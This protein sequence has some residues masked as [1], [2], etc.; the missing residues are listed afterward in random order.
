MRAAAGRSRREPAGGGVLAQA[1]RG[2]GVAE[3]APVSGRSG[4]RALAG[5]LRGLAIVA[6]G[7]GGAS[8]GHPRLVGEG[9][10]GPAAARRR[11]AG[12][13]QGPGCGR[14]LRR[15]APELRGPPGGG[16][17]C[18]WRGARAQNRR[19]RG[20]PGAR[21]VPERLGRPL[22][23]PGGRGRRA[24]GRGVMVPSSGPRPRRL[25][26]PRRRGNDGR[27]RRD[28]LRSQRR[29]RSGSQSWHAELLR[30][31]DSRGLA[32]PVAAL[33]GRL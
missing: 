33:A 24:D 22:G 2:R 9:R 10:R 25:R 13:G 31:G 30:R 16:E 29:R 18:P 1:P 28:R 6:R 20:D 17:E 8:A 19:A 3:G 5:A 26:R 27:P 14:H 11:A 23:V 32:S 15:G 7:H 4:R 21:L 12:V